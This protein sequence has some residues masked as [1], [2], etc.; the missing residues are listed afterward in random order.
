MKEKRTLDADYRARENARRRVK[1]AEKKKF[2]EVVATLLAAIEQD[3]A[4]VHAE[5]NSM[6]PKS[7][8]HICKVDDLYCPVHYARD[9]EAED[10]ARNVQYLTKDFADV[11]VLTTG[12]GLFVPTA[13]GEKKMPEPRPVFVEGLWTNV[14]SHVAS[15]LV[16]LGRPQ[17]EIV[18]DMGLI[19]MKYTRET[20]TR[21]LAAVRGTPVL[22]VRLGFQLSTNAELSNV[23]FEALRQRELEGVKAKTLVIYESFTPW[24]KGHKAYSE[25]LDAY[26]E[27]NFTRIKMSATKPSAKTDDTITKETSR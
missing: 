3:H 27:A 9:P 1:Y 4:E 15:Y 12:S 10:R 13:D 18:T 17:Y 14:K 24:K 2:A 25:D 23:V 22:I 19:E 11:K 5:V 7:E 6:I 20:E 8:C 26:L 21:F 16:A